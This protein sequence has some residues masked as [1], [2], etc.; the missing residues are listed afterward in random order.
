MEYVMYLYRFCQVLKGAGVVTLCQNDAEVKLYME[1]DHH[2]SSTECDVGVKVQF[3]QQYINSGVETP[4]KELTMLN[5]IEK[6]KRSILHLKRRRRL[7]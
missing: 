4:Y 3:I 5:P 2:I 7:I 6:F 1:I